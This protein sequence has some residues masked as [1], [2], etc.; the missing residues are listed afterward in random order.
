MSLCRRGPLR[1]S[2][3]VHALSFRPL[4][5]LLGRVSGDSLSSLAGFI[6]IGMSLTITRC[7]RPGPACVSHPILLLTHPCLAGHNIPSCS[8][9]DFV[10]K[11]GKPYSKIEHEKDEPLLMQLSGCVLY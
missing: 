1:L 10:R 8:C 3:R 5:S 9:L 4:L 11:S 2:F 7:L 6:F